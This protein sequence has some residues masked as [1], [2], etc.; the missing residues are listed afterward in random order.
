MFVKV[1]L[2]KIQRMKLVTTNCRKTVAQVKAETGCQYVINGTLFKFGNAKPLCVYRADGKTI[3]KDKYKYWCYAWDEGRDI[4]MVHSDD[5]G[6]YDYAFACVTLIKDGKKANLIYNDELG[7]KRGRS[8]IGIDKN[9]N[10]VLFC[11]ADGT[12]YAMTPE[13]LAEY[14]LSVCECKSA[15]M[16]DSGGSSSCDFNGQ[17]VT[18]SRKV[19]NYICVWTDGCPYTEPKVT[20]RLGSKGEGAKWVQWHLGIEVTGCFDDKSVEALKEAQKKFGLKVDGLCG[21][22]TRAKLKGGF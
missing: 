18:T 8:A 11:S 16:L 13:T 5:I 10:L 15:I 4:K 12:G 6:K 9:G 1:P 3:T 7:G 14:M 20:V 2:S 17:R 21:P 19:A 22:L